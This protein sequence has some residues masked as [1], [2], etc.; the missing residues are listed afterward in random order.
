[1]DGFVATRQDDV[2]VIGKD[3]VFVLASHGVERN[4]VAIQGGRCGL[5]RKLA[6]ADELTWIT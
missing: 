6:K 1:M 2:G 5:L 3:G 4:D